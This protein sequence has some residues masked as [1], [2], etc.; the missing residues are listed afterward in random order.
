MKNIIISIHPKYC[1]LIA[2]G[3]FVNRLNDLA[4]QYGKEEK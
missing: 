3:R 4:E 1:E 2:I